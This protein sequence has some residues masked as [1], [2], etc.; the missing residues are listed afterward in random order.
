MRKS[1]PQALNAAADWLE[2][3]PDKHIDVNLARDENGVE[4][5]PSTPGATCFC[6]VGRVAKEL[7]VPVDANVYNFMNN[8]IGTDT[9]DDIWATNDSWENLEDG[10]NPAV[11]PL[12]RAIANDQ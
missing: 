10:G 6:A 1:I 7:E 11:I 9:V 3:N 5:H 12:L 8:L 4:C 2:A